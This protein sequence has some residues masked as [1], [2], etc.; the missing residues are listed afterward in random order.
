MSNII[1]SYEDVIKDKRIKNYMSSDIK[2][3]F[4]NPVIVCDRHGW[5]AFNTEENQ[6]NIQK[7]VE[8]MSEEELQEEIDACRAPYVEAVSKFKINYKHLKKISDMDIYKMFQFR[9]SKCEQELLKRKSY[10]RNIEDIIRVLKSQ[11]Y[12]CHV[13]PNKNHE[14]FA[15]KSIDDE[16]YVYFS[17]GYRFIVVNGH[18]FVGNSLTGIAAMQIFKYLP[19]IRM[20]HI[21]G[22]RHAFR[23][24]DGWEV[25]LPKFLHENVVN[26]E[27]PLC[28]KCGSA[29]YLDVGYYPKLKDYAEVWMCGNSKKKCR[30]KY[31]ADKD[32]VVLGKAF[33]HIKREAI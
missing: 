28:P 13:K 7:D 10:G 14:V 26:H 17:T 29:M 18:R 22:E 27:Y 30:K 20:F 32:E 4:K 5:K 12:R 8:D 2:Y 21:S 23:Y 24:E 3:R 15:Q 11:G 31:L 9:R 16:N 19:D 6:L 25:A 1:L 33:P